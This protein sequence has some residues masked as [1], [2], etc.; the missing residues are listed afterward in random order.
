[1]KVTQVQIRS[2]L[3]KKLS[4]DEAWALR[5][6][7]RVHEFQTLSEQAAG[8]THEANS[9]GF[10]GCDAEFLTSL[11]RQYLTRGSLSPKQMAFVLKKIHRYWGQVKSLIPAEKLESLVVA[12]LQREC[13]HSE[14]AAMATA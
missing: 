7:V 10:S 14:S 1:M 5:A 9:V 8:I 11:T 4:S 3:K 13:A 12:D 6:L 2:F